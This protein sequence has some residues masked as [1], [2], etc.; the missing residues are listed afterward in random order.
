MT[1]PKAHQRTYDYAGL[2]RPQSLSDEERARIGATIS[3]LPSSVTTVLDVGCGDGRLLRHL[4]AA[5][6]AVGADCATTSLRHLDGQGVCADAQR[7]PFRDSAFDLSLCCEVLEHLPSLMLAAVVQELARVSRRYVLVTVPYKEPLSRLFLRCWNCGNVFHIWGHLHSFSRR[8]LDS[9]FPDFHLV[10]RRY[11]GQRAPY[12]SSLITR[13]NQRF[14]RRFADADDT[15]IC[16]NCGNTQFTRTPRNVVTIA[17]GLVHRFT[18][19]LTPTS[20]RN[21]VLSLYARNQ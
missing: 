5:I 7:L 15:T 17:C 14:G 21:W 12:H 1:L 3:L 19:A 8:T 2:Y 10:S 6:R 20:Q 13:L 18:A 16:L 11:C 4:P 9:L